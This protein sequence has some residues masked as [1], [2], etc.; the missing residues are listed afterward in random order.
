MIFREIGRHLCHRH[1]AAR[2]CCQTATGSC[3]Q[4]Y[5]YETIGMILS[6]SGTARTDALFSIAFCCLAS[7]TIF[8]TNFEDLIIRNSYLEHK[9][10]FFT[11]SKSIAS[12]GIFHFQEFSPSIDRHCTDF[13]WILR[14][15]WNIWP[16]TTMFGRTLTSC[17]RQTLFTEVDKR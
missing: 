17:H 14:Q 5:R 8:P 6:R 16:F 1:R 10:L 12:F 9:K 4:R 2:R 15:F 13:V 3:R 11:I 7:A